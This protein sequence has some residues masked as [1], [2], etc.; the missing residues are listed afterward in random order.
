[1]KIN[2]RVRNHALALALNS[3]LLL[4]AALPAYAAITD[5]FELLSTDICVLGEA[6]ANMAI[7]IVIFIGLVF[8]ALGGIQYAQSGGDKMA[9]EQARGKITGAVVGTLVGIGGYFLIRLVIYILRG[10]ETVPC[11]PQLPS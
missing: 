7:G 11:E 5:P 4:F 1:M 3:S 8:L 10:S 2:K 9:V 6:L